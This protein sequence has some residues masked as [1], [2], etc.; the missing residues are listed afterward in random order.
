MRLF[1]S[2][3]FKK[4]NQQDWILIKFPFFYIYEPINWLVIILMLS[5][6]HVWMRGSS[7]PPFRP[8][9]TQINR[10]EGVVEKKRTI[11][12]F[13]RSTLTS[14]PTSRPLPTLASLLLW[15]HC[16][17]QSAAPRSVYLS[18][19]CFHTYGG[20]VFVETHRPRWRNFPIAYIASLSVQKFNNKFT[21]IRISNIEPNNI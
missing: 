1:F 20:S 2:F 11:W 19:C 18:P 13:E 9:S 3:F 10:I 8:A 21:K 14:S 16:T 15:L 5:I 17:N 4:K 7:S 6:W 12:N